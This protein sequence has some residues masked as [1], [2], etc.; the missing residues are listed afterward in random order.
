VSQLVT[1]SNEVAVTGSLP[2]LRG[3]LIVG[4]GRF[5]G[6]AGRGEVQKRG[7]SGRLS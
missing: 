3:R 6:C 4:D 2:F 1:N 5:L 7:A